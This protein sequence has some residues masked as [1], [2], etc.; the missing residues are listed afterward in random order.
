MSDFDPSALFRR[1]HEDECGNFRVMTDHGLIDVMQW[2]PGLDEDN[3]F[4]QLTVDV[5]EGEVFG[6]QVQVCSLE[7]LRTM[8]RAAGRPIDEA[9]LDALS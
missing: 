6:V 1:L 2:I 3:A 5:L 7:N 9:D 4:D 8:K